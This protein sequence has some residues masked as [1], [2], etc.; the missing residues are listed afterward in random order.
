MAAAAFSVTFDLAPSIK[1]LARFQERAP[2]GIARA[3]NRSMTSARVVV[4]QDVGKDMGIGAS[5]I[6]QRITLKEA[7]PDRHVATLSASPKRIGLIDMKANQTRTGVSYRGR[8]G[9]RVRVDHAFIAQMASGH[10][11]VYQ[12]LTKARLPI[13]E[14]FGP[15]IWLVF[16]RHADAGRARAVEQ[17]KKNLQS[18]FRFAVLQTGGE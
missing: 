11:G 4:A 6:R 12:R 15:S 14:L 18:E 13:H 17:L 7:T 10:R 1:K 16:T 8:N 2:F 9:S 5:V 3:L